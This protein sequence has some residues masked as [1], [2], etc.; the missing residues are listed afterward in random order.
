MLINYTD[1][2]HLTVSA[3]QGLAFRIHVLEEEYRKTPSDHFTLIELLHLELEKAYKEFMAI[4][5]ISQKTTIIKK[6]A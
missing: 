1:P 2:A 6:I 4:N 3:V 5:T